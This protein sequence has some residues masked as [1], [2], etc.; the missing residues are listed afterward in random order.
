MRDSQIV[1]EIV[2]KYYGFTDVENTKYSII[3]HIT[4]SGNE[5][6]FELL[7]KDLDSIGTTAFTNDFPDNQIIVINNA[8]LGRERTGIKT[9]MF[10]ISIVT[11]V[12][13]GYVYSSGYYAPV[14]LPTGI[15]Y[16][17]I[18]Y[19]LPVMGIL[20]IREFGKYLSL[21]KN[22]IKYIFPIFVPSPGIG[23]LG[24]INSNKNQFRES[25]SMIRTGTISLL[26]GFI[27]SIALIII[28]SYSSPFIQYNAAIRSPVFILN[29]PAIY[30]VILGHFMPVSLAP[31]PLSL[32]G[33]TGLVTT[34]LNAI[35]V[36]FLDG[37][38]VFS[39]IL[40][41][42]FRYV[43]YIAMAALLFSSILYPYI[44]ILVI[45][46]FLL[47][48]RGALPMNNLVKPGH[49]MKYLAAIAILIILLGFAPLP[50]HNI[51][52][53]NVDISDSCYVIDK[54]NP[55]NVTVNIT[56]TEDN[57]NIIPLFSVHP[58]KFKIEGYKRDNSTAVTYILNI[59]TYKANYSGI[60][61]FNI[62]VNTGIHKFYKTVKVFFVDLMKN[63]DVNNSTNPFNLTA[64]QNS[65]FNLTLYNNGS[66]PMIVKIISISSN[67]NVYTIL[68]TNFTQSFSVSSHLNT[69]IPPHS[70]KSIEV[71]AQT[72]GVWEL[73]ISE[74][75]N[76]IPLM[77][78]IHILPK[79]TPHPIPN[80]FD[81]G[82]WVPPIVPF[83]ISGYSNS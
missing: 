45:L 37:G 64:Y 1:E 71:E 13:T 6:T 73:I 15:L 67:M 7:L 53:S 5:K 16:G 76:P 24:T 26:S 52:N 8:N 49:Y 59:I 39:G 78:T 66:T 14:S 29:F 22:H 2:Q 81:N 63:V 10:L 60:R 46:L 83:N 42:R 20:L 23:T 70:N 17:V 79:P 57:V 41:R 12:Y 27:V 72:P 28:G 68:Q 11:L 55:H 19:A 9:L 32:A 51:S 62:T 34:A 61:H 54:Q 75:N 48:I 21:K 36:G 35:P 18:F 82:T 38:L 69:V 65:P 40:G 80:P 44:L 47:G 33:Y 43:S 3:F 77:I 30:P 50:L 74:S 31:A 56:V 58:G 4:G 25:K